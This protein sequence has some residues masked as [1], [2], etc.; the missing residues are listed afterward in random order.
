MSSLT[1]TDN[2]PIDPDDELLVSYLDGEL[3]REDETDLENR[4]VASETLRARLQTLQSGWD[5]LDDLPEATPSLKLVE[6]TLEMAVSDLQDIKTSQPWVL[7]TLKWP[8]IVLVTSLLGIGAAFG[9]SQSIKS[10][11]YKQQLDDLAIVENLD[12]YLRGGDIELM[13]LLASSENWASMVSAGREIDEFIPANP[14]AVSETP[15]EEREEVVQKL[16][17]EKL[18]QLNLR[19]ERF[20]ALSQEDQEKVRRTAAAVRSQPDSEL[21]LNTMQIYAIWSQSLTA[22]IRDAIESKEPVIRKTAIDDAIEQTQ[23][24]ISQRSILKL[25]DEV[26]ELIYFALQQIVRHRVEQGMETTSNHLK[27]TRDRFQESNDPYFSTVAAMVFTGPQRNGPNANTT[28]RR[29]SIWL[30]TGD[31]PAPI[32]NIE[33]STLRLVIPDSAIEILD[34]ITGGD[35]L[36]ETVTLRAWSEEAARRHFPIK[37]REESTYLERYI[38]TP[39]RERDFIDL[40]P[41]K[42]IL[43]ELSRDS[44][45]P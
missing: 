27:R 38:A 19:W 12:A 11:T 20:N 17:I 45:F 28:N 36:L 32:T 8:L 14:N 7:P 2:A 44:P 35:P 4:L 23:I 5:L 26:T 1:K 6:S 41:P 16:P 18:S 3:S 43:S 15:L 37:R 34:L 42:E 10:Q 22:E 24:L 13:R 25:D 40:L 21:L 33:L 31:R 39:T 30:G 9:V 29:R